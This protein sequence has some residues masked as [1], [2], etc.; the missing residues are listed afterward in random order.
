MEE[1]RTVAFND[2]VDVV[3]AQLMLVDQKAIRGRVAFEQS[4]GAFDPRNAPDERARE[5]RDDAKMRDE[6][7]NVM[8]FPRPAR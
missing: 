2:A 3:N 4:D 6:E 8:F 7:R 1:F 5:Q